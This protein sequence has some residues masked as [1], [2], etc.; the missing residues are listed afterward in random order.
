MVL[1]VVLPM[2]PTLSALA[3]PQ[4]DPPPPVAITP[5]GGSL[6]PNNSTYSVTLTLAQAL[7]A[8]VLESG[9]AA[10]VEAAAA[11]RREALS[12]TGSSEADGSAASTTTADTPPAPAPGSVD[13]AKA[14]ASSE[15][16][17]RAASVPAGDARWGGNDPAAGALLVLGI[18]GS[19]VF[20]SPC[21]RRPALR[22]VATT[23]PLGRC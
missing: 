15:C 4:D 6:L 13:E 20:G 21:S 11:A 8:K 14:I 5:G 23:R 3:G 1:A 19:A 12:D 9:Q 18:L 17:W 10:Q 2:L 16:A 7:A 22:G